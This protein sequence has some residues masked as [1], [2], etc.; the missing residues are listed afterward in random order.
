MITECLITISGTWMI[1]DLANIL[2]RILC[3]IWMRGET[4]GLSKIQTMIVFQTSQKRKLRITC[5][6]SSHL[7][8][9][10]SKGLLIQAIRWRWLIFKKQLSF[11]VK[12]LS[13]FIL[14][15]IMFQDIN[16]QQDNN[17]FIKI[18]WLIEVSI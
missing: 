16:I 5:H 14:K 3:A 4:F 18:I 12:H 11:V 8:K 15:Y 17:C 6:C 9:I 7:V 1:S 13:D 10:C 2:F